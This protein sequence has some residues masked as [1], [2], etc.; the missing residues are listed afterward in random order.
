V[1]FT[2]LACGRGQ[3]VFDCVPQTPLAPYWSVTQKGNLLEIAHGRDGHFPQYAA[4]HL[5]SGYFRLNYGPESGWGTSVVL[6]PSFWSGGRLHQGA[7]VQASWTPVCGQLVVDVAGTI[8]GL[9][10]NTAVRLN[11][12]AGDSITAAVTVRTRGDMPLDNRPD[13]AFRLVA[14]SSMRIAADTWDARSAFL[15]DRPLAIPESGW[16]VRPPLRGTRFGL[17][18]G[19]STWKRNA[20]TIEIVLEDR[21]AISGWVTPRRDQTEDNVGLWAATEGVAR[22]W[23]YRITARR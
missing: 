17:V 11:P 9:S 3:A 21:R 23:R 16:I 15:G 2:T 4:L 7:P 5:E 8:S 18:G 1:L 19:T 20:P 13:E 6:L 14:L 10:A 12:P 22:E